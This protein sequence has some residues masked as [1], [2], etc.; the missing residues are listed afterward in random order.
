MDLSLPQPHL[1]LP[2]GDKLPLSGNTSIGR[3]GQA[4]I[5]LDGSKVSRIHAHIY[6]IEGQYQ[7]VDSQS[8]NGTYVNRQRI[9]GP[10]TLKSGDQIS[11]GGHTLVFVDEQKT[12]NPVEAPSISDRTMEALEKTLTWLVLLD[13]KD[14]TNLA[15]QQG[16]EAYA[17]LLSA[18]FNT[19]REIIV[20]HDGAINKSTGDGLLA[21]WKDGEGNRAEEVASALRELCEFQLQ[22]PPAFRMIVHYGLVG[23]GGGAGLGEE[24]LSGPEVHL[25]FRAEKSL[26]QTPSDFGAT[27][28]AAWG[29]EKW[30]RRTGLS[31]FT[32]K[33]FEGQYQ[34]YHLEALPLG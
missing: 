19:C 33:G 9:I 5:P 15:F 12:S 4:T 20:Q 32:P 11:I 31:E 1:V 3:S 29:L 26:S 23:I 18:W 21:Y 22:S 2:T 16:V 8:R 10:A 24:Q 30:M 34:I 25:I 14:S 7:V 13:V 28:A 6:Q 27:E 17:S